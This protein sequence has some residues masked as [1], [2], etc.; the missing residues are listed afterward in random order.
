MSGTSMDGIDAALIETDGVRHIKC[1]DS[2][3][4]NYEPAFHW[5]LKA[6]EAAVCQRHGDMN[7]AKLAFPAIYQQFFT[8]YASTKPPSPTL[9]DI[10]ETSTTYHIQAVQALLNKCNLTPSRIDIIGYHGQTLYHNPKA[11]TTIQIGNGKRMAET[12]HIPV[13]NDFRANDV[14]HGGQGAPFAPLYHQA[15]AQRDGYHKAVIANCGGI[16]NLSVIT[17][18]GETDIVGFDTGPGNCLLDAFIKTKTNGEYLY[19]K[20]GQFALAGRTDEAV[21][22]QLKKKTFIKQP[23]FIQQKPPK[24]LDRSDM[25]LL[26]ELNDISIH[27]GA[28]TLATFTAQCIAEHLIFMKD[29]P[30]TWVLAGGGWKHPVIYNKLKKQLSTYIPDLTFKHA[31]EIGWDGDALEAQ[32]FAF[33]AVRHLLQLPPPA[34]ED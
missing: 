18:A 11:R 10:I 31:N 21:L 4:L 14:K 27:D 20:D 17:G 29:I 8:Q 16:A 19:D 23:N 13:I 34:G 28:A 1:I 9:N 7:A 6:A 32:L 26:P 25:Q 33:L 5:Q 30:T 3:Q 12:L 22:S 15:L 2:I 24:S